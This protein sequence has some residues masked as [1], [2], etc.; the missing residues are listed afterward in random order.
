MEK[1]Q[2][3]A[4]VKLCKK[5][6][7]YE[8]YKEEHFNEDPRYIAL[9]TRI[10][11]AD[12]RDMHKY[13]EEYERLTR[14]IGTGERAELLYRDL[15]KRFSHLIDEKHFNYDSLHKILTLIELGKADTLERAIEMIDGI[16]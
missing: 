2:Y 11:R 16:N 15:R 14:E 6:A 3:E 9:M 4:L 8:S 10:A 5:F 7:E 1:E 12:E 13:D